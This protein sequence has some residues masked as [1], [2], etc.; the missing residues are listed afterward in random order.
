MEIA[1]ILGMDGITTW[2]TFTYLG[3]PIFKAA[4]RVAHWLPLLDKLKNKILAWGA[5]WLNKAGKVIL[6][7]SI[8]TSL[9]IFQCSVLLAPKTITN[10]INE[11]LRR[12]LWEGGRNN[13]KKLH[14][15]GWDKITRP[16]IEGGLQIRDVATQN[17][18]MG[19]KILWNLITGRKTWSKQTLK[20]KYFTGDRQR[21]LERPTKLQKGSPVFSLCKRALPFFTP[22]LTWS[23]GNGEKINI[24]EDSILGEQPLINYSDMS[25]IRDWLHAKN[26]RT[27]MDISNWNRDE[28]ESWAS[29]NLGELP[30]DLEEEAV[31]LLNFLQGK[32]PINA[33]A[34][35]KRS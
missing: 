34:K 22:K 35:D 19:G 12:F 18:A 10:R 30:H 7:N 20:K 32:S 2:D 6:M 27:L 1:R 4:I 14:L 29:W 16:K 11:L 23:P 15:V 17:L 25:N 26:C 24:W 8:L 3:I 21:C 31:S 28:D 13:E 5:S 33:K 9:P